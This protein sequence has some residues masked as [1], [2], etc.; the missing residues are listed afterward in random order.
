MRQSAHPIG[1]LFRNLASLEVDPEAETDG[2]QRQEHRDQ[3]EE[4]LG[5]VVGGVVVVET[6]FAYPGIGAAAATAG[7]GLDVVTVLAFMLFNGFI[8]IVAN[9]VIDVLY[10]YIDP[11]VRLH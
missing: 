10:A 9:V 11:R 5:V 4:A 1:R 7:V 6:V 2:T 3:R 8:L